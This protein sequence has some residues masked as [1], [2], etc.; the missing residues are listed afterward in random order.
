M[1]RNWVRKQ[2]VWLLSLRVY[3]GLILIGNLIWETLQ[4]PLYTI[5][6]AGASSE[7][8]FA[9]LHCTLGDVLIAGST[10]TLALIITGD[11]RWPQLRFSLIASLTIVLGLAYTV[12]SEWLNVMVRAAWA[13][14]DWM[15]IIPI[16]GLRIGL[17][18]LLQWIVVPSAAFTI[19][20]WVTARYANGGRR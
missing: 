18:P 9:V 14:S 7:R 5:W 13:Y 1:R 20:R 16:A 11:H 6:M 4:L 8:A 17:S 15:P 2:R 12:F 3:F 10:L 19:T